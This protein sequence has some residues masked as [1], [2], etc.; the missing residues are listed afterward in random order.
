MWAWMQTH[1]SSIQVLVSLLTTVV[2]IAYLHVFLSSYRR[3]TRSSLLISREGAR[4]LDSRCII[5]NMGSEPA[6][7]MDV[8]AEFET[9][10]KRFT[11]SVVDRLEL[12][13]QD[14][15]PGEASSA[16]GPMESGGYVDV[17][18][19]GDV[20]TRAH[21]QFQSH[22]FTNEIVNLRL[23]AIAA[24]NQ[25][26]HL[27]AACRSFEFSFDEDGD[28]VQVVPVEAAAKQIRSR[29]KQKQIRRLLEGLQREAAIDSPVS[30]DL[31]DQPIF[32]RR[33][34]QR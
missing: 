2:W 6:F 24:T 1:A 3:Q 21:R 12:W 22:D 7:L 32:G 15:E 4:G 25:A 33:N 31:V 8:L 23:I 29:R 27:A 26:R 9:E 20:L 17:G 30:D 16:Q 14:Q 10:G 13:E 34:G 11:A 5:A 18:S 28:V 19:F